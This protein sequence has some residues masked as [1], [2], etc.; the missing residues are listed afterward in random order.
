MYPL[1]SG[2]GRGQRCAEGRNFAM[3]ATA[4]TGPDDTR[5]GGR[6][7]GSNGPL[8][9]ITVNLT[10]RASRALDLAIELT[11]DTKTDTVNRALQVY[12]YLEQVTARGGSVY[13]REAAGAELE[14]LKVF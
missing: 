8:E 9:R 14:R 11:G 12:A 1:T 4:T 7:N 5:S 10:G 2:K 3:S 6:G 13:V